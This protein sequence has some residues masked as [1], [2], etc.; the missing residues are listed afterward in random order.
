MAE[1]PELR[2]RFLSDIQCNPHVRSILA[3]WDRLALPDGWLVAGCLFHGVLAPNPLTDHGALFEAK[4]RSYQERWPWLR[5]AG[6]TIAPG[7]S[8]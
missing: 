5:V 7:T 8:P 6:A 4:A 3:C 2:A 1:S